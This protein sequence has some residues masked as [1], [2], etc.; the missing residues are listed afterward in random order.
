MQEIKI[1][2]K[3]KG[4]LKSVEVDGNKVF[5]ANEL[6]EGES[7]ILKIHLRD[8]IKPADAFSIERKVVM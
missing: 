8:W 2:L 6:K 7:V 3:E 1:L 4:C 5:D